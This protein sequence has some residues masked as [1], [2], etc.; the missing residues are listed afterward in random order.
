MIYRIKSIGHKLEDNILE[1]TFIEAG[2]IPG[3]IGDRRNRCVPQ[4]LIGNFQNFNDSELEVLLE[5][6]SC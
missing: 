2:F 1:N 5:E 4:I 6:D 3:R